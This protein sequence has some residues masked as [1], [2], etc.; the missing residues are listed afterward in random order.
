[1][2][3]GD[4]AVVR[5]TVKNVL[6]SSGLLAQVAVNTPAFEFNADG[7]YKG[8]L[9][10]PGA[11]NLVT[12]S[13]EFNDASWTKNNLTISA[14]STTAP[15][16]TSTADKFIATAVTDAHFITRSGIPAGTANTSI[17]A[18]QAEFKFI[19]L[20]NADNGVYAVFDLSLGTVVSVAVSALISGAKI[21]LVGDG[22]Y[23]CSLIHTNDNP[24]AIGILLINN[25]GDV[26]YLG[27]ATSGIFIWQAQIE[28]GS[29]AT[30]PIYTVASTVA[31]AA[32]AVTLTG[33]SSLIGQTEGTLYV[34]VDWR[35]ATGGNQHLLSVNDNS[36]SNR[37]AIYRANSSAQLRMLITANGVEQTNQ[38]VTDV[39]LTGIQKIALAYNT[40]DAVL[41]RNGALAST[42]TVVNLSAMAT[43]SQIDV[44]QRAGGAEK[45]NMWIRSVALFPTRLD[46]ATLAS[47]TTL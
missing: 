15:D 30:S 5:S 32:D 13:Q 4:F 16:G 20:G 19:G 2:A 8:L 37:V 41:Y 39:S 33:A 22:W 9:V 10:E 44:A 14:N 28:T 11:T 7:T 25:S 46:N 47:I 27:D 1:M 17:Y 18:K 42:D 3:F 26:S 45:A 29:V 40:N 24:K 31:R 35:K 34:E 12:Y 38:G 6:N 36:T 43:L 23:R 21:E